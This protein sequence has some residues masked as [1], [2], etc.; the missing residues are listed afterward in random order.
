MQEESTLS[1]EQLEELWHLCKSENDKDARDELTLHYVNLVKII[2]K[3]VMPKYNAFNEYDDLINAGVLG[4]VDAIDKYELGK[5]IK[6]ETYASI[7]IR[8][9]IIDYIRSLDWASDSLRRRI[10]AVN[11][12]YSDLELN[13]SRPATEEEVAAEVGLTPEQVKDTVMKSHI[14]NAV[15]FEETLS[16]TSLA[17]KL[18]SN[19]SESPDSMLMQDEVRRRLADFI[20]TLPKRER[21]VITM[22]YYEGFYAKNIADILGI[23]TARVSQIHS[24]V[25]NK[26]RERL[27]DLQDSL[28]RW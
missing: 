17:H 28:Y 26:M 27:E 3:R 11:K 20:D 21:Q 8:G 15:S 10:S 24:K 9:E 23:S 1:N 2:V 6:F 14:F 19:E 7:R 16:N 12:A 25:I 4:L 22:Y 5:N 18:V 13:N